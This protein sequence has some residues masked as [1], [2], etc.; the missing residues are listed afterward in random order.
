MPREGKNRK[1]FKFNIAWVISGV[2][3]NCRKWESHGFISFTKTVE[4]P[5]STKAI[6]LKF[7]F[8]CHKHWVS[9][10]DGENEHGSW[11]CNNGNFTFRE[12]SK[13]KK[14]VRGYIPLTE[15]CFHQLNLTLVISRAQ[16][17]DIWNWEGGR[18][19]REVFMGV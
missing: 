11:L 3:L 4:E 2:R 15:T 1:P 12:A 7:F 13:E 18:K 14:K 9:F 17:A 8:F 6:W 5:F 10:T 19:R 16:T